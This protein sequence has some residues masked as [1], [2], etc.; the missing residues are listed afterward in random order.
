MKQLLAVLG[1]ALG[2]VAIAA[3]LI[4]LFAFP[5]M[6]L[7]NMLVPQVFNGPV[8]SFWQTFGLMLLVRFILPTPAKQFKTK[9]Q[10]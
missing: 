3:I 8:L 7:W 4:F 2:A 9:S 1:V 6:W 5:A 10:D